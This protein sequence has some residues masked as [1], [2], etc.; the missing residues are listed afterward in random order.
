MELYIYKNKSE[1]LPYEEIRQAFEK[2]S[3][4]ETTYEG[5][6]ACIKQHSGRSRYGVVHIV[7]QKDAGKFI[8][9]VPEEKIPV[10]YMDAVLATIKN[11]MNT[12]KGLNPFSSYNFNYTIVDG[13]FHP[14]DSDI[15]SYEIA[16]FLAISDIIGFDH[17][18]LKP[19]R[20]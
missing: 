4:T 15:R 14:V 5:K 10:V 3:F 13:S 8:W 11:I 7:M 1:Y 16:T 12:P 17:V 6:G 20:K 19:Y 9:N 2:F 18:S